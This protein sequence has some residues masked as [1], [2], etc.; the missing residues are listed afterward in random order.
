M[1]PHPGEPELRASAGT[2]S[3]P[4]PASRPTLV[5]SSSGCTQKTDDPP[6]NPQARGLRDRGPCTVSAKTVA[7]LPTWMGPGRRSL[8]TAELQARGKPITEI[9]RQMA[10]PGTAPS[11]TFRPTT[12]APPAP[13]VRQPPSGLPCTRP[14]TNAPGR[15]RRHN[16]LSIAVTGTPHPF[17]PNSDQRPNLSW[18]PTGDRGKPSP[19]QATTRTVEG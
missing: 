6:T 17:T 5:C 8:P 3:P 16:R 2:P 19:D 18:R 10:G 14:R 13:T 9:P 7:G 1:G 15:R 12:G 4:L 11:S